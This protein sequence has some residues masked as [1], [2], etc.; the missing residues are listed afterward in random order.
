MSI[1]AALNKILNESH[2]LDAEK[3]LSLIEPVIDWLPKD[4]F[5][6]ILQARVEITYQIAP[7]TKNFNIAG[8]VETEAFQSAKLRKIDH[9]PVEYLLLEQLATTCFGNWA[10][11][12]CEYEIYKIKS[13]N[14][15]K[16]LHDLSIPF[17]SNEESYTSQV[18]PKIETSQRQYF[19]RHHYAP[20]ALNDAISLINLCTFVAELKWY[21]M[22][23][24]LDLSRTGCH[25]ILEYQPDSLTHPVIV[26]SAKIQGWSDSSQWLYFTPFFKPDNWQLCLPESFEKKYIDSEVLQPDFKPRL[27]SA[28]NFEKHFWDSLHKTDKICEVLRLTVSGN[29]QQCAFYLYLAQKHIMQ[30]LDEQGYRL[31]FT[32]IEQPWMI[33]FYNTLQ[34]NGYFHTS[35]KDLNDTG[36]YTYKGV[37]VIPNLRKE[38]DSVCFREYK[39]RVII[40]KDKLET[41]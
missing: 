39:Q 32:I 31:T 23:A 26:S 5:S 30:Y 9:W 38:L 28:K 27:E 29:M 6:T 16:E 14:P 22:L 3:V 20:L 25:F 35:R 4:I 7:Y 2:A 1:E 15:A 12:W 36:R 17:P 18:I 34:L 37:W 40:G 11:F 21:E 33:R 19:T 13:Q 8:I 41:D 10:A 24:T